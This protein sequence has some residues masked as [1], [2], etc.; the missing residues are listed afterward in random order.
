MKQAMA[1]LTSEQI[2]F[3]CTECKVTRDQIRCMSEDEFYNAV[4]DPMCDIECAET[5]SSDEPLTRHCQMAADIVTVL[6][7]AWAQENG[8]FDE[9]DEQFFE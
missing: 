4:Y 9:E 7:N 1:E 3:I 6:G 5:P 8:C 2:D